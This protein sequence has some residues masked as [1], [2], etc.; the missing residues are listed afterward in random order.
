MRI[1]H[2]EG[3]YYCPN[4][5]FLFNGILIKAESNIVTRL[6][7]KMALYGW[8]ICNTDPKK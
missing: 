5:S 3:F 1:A 4:N 6:S 7:Y 8:E 2:E